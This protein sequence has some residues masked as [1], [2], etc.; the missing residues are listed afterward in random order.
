MKKLMQ[1]RVQAGQRIFYYA[2]VKVILFNVMVPDTVWT[3]SFV[4]LFSQ[5]NRLLNIEGQSPVPLALPCCL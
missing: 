1:G 4:Y 2:E 5:G 3:V